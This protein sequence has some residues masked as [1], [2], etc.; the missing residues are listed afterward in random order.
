MLLGVGE[1]F[2][3]Y[4]VVRRVGAGAMGEVYLAKHPRLPRQDALKLLAANTETD[5]TF[6]DRFMR[7]ADLVCTFRHPHIVGVFDRGEYQGRLWIAMEYVDGE[8]VGKILAH[9]YPRGMP[10]VLVSDIVTAVAS[11]LDYAHRQRLL[12]RDVKP[13][14]ILI[15]DADDVDERRILLSDFGIARPMDEQNS[16]TAT[17]MTV[18]TVNYAAPEQLMGEPLDG[19]ADQYSLAATAYQLLTGRPMYADSNVA[20]VISRHLSAAVPRLAGTRPDLAVLDAVFEIA[21]AKNP[22][23]R[24]PTCGAF[25]QAVAEQLS[26]PPGHGPSLAATALAPVAHG[27]FVADHPHSVDRTPSATPLTP[28]WYPN[29]NGE[30]E[31]LY[32]DGR[33]WRMAPP[34][35]TGTTDPGSHAVSRARSP[36]SLILAIAVPLVLAGAG[37]LLWS[38]TRHAGSAEPDAS[39]VTADSTQFL[40]P[41]APTAQSTRTVTVPAKPSTT[42]VLVAPPTPT[43]H[44]P[45]AM[46]TAVGVIEGTCDEGGTCGLKQRTAPYTDSPRLYSDDLHDGSAVTMSCQT[47]GDLRSNAGVGSSRIWFRLD[48]GAYVPAVYV[49]TTAT[50]LAVC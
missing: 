18:G 9:R 19:R 41:A 42:T 50:Q 27:E 20:V 15:A 14:N 3:G 23:N 4:T 24:F 34:P 35:S 12:H 48:N 46:P 49:T 33:D 45:A 28:G 22:R 7:E 40:P 30:P 17:N 1:E 25:A 47:I 38:Q 2:A 6:R 16:L 5:P 11:A 8:D 36:L 37:F 26:S 39:T 43:G 32:W 13:A 21:L 29:P 31:T 10:A 44:S